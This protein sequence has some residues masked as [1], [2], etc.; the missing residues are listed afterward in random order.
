[1][2][3]TIFDNVQ[4][5]EKYYCFFCVFYIEITYFLSNFAENLKYGKISLF[6]ILL[7]FQQ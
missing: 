6:N 2:K 3:Q 5:I 4:I 7:L 1:M